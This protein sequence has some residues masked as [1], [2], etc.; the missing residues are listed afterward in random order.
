M[1][2]GPEAAGPVGDAAE[3]AALQRLFGRANL[4]GL[5]ITLAGIPLALGWVSATLATGFGLSALS[6]HVLR[7]RLQG[8]G[9]R[10][11][12]FGL[13]AGL[14]ELAADRWLVDTLGV[15]V[16]A[17]G[18][19]FLVASPLYMPFSWGGMLQ[20]GVLF[21]GTLLRRAGPVA[22]CAAVALGV[23][24][25]LPVYEHLAH[26][27]GWWVY[28]DT[29]MALGTVPY[30]I[31]LGEVLVGAPLPLL[32]GPLARRGP[33]AAVLLGVAVGLWIF[34]AYAI[35]FALCGRP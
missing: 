31:A 35:A 14:V 25:V 30:F 26:V 2:P 10:L 20:A 11:W 6:V 12:L 29:P 16:Y 19:P 28:R 15:L 7:A 5:A 9:A 18:G 22:A 27:S 32:A 17:D 21:G 33:L 8:F 13:S 34:V 23:G 4:V 3:H 24:A 1:P